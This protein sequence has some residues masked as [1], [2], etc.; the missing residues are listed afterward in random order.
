MSVFGSTG[1]SRAVY[2][3]GFGGT[4]DLVSG[5]A[6]AVEYSVGIAFGGYH[7]NLLLYVCKLGNSVPIHIIL[8]FVVLLHWGQVVL[9]PGALSLW[10]G[11]K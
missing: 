6:V 5:A 2:S 9:G 3:S 10:G 8:L 4:E 7:P 1:S 11:L